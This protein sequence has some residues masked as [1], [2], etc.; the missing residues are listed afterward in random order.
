MASTRDYFDHH[1][2]LTERSLVEALG[3]AEL[4]PVEVRPRFLP[5]TTKSRLPQHPLLVWLYLKLPLAHRLLGQQSW[6]VAAR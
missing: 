6:I 2:P 3:L 4:T 5:F 1:L